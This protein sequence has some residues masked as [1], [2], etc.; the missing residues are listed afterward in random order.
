[1]VSQHYD[2]LMAPSGLRG[3]QF[4][5]LTVISNSDEL[6]ITDLADFLVM[7]RTTLTRNLKP[8]EKQGYL[9]ILPGMQDRRSRR[10]LLTDAGKKIQHC[11]MPYWRQAQNEMVNYLGESKAVNFIQHLQV[12]AA[13]HGIR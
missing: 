5:I 11:A 10:I 6:S 9:N 7:D 3:T 13:S 2:K 12:A 1:V 4:T 8:L